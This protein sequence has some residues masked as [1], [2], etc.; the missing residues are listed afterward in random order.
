MEGAVVT[1]VQSHGLLPGI[2]REVLLENGWAQEASLTLADLEKAD[3]VFLTSSTRGIHPVVK[4]G[5]REFDRVGSTTRSLMEAF[6]DLQ[7]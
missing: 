6:R 4:C 2:I 5:A 3:E 1:P 7:K